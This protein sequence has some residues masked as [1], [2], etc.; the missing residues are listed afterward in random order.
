MKRYEAPNPSSAGRVTANMPADTGNPEVFDMYGKRIYL[1]GK[2]FNEACLKID[3]KQT[4]EVPGKHIVKFTG[5][6]KSF[7]DRVII[8]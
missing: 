4:G 6:E 3:L 7:T 5:G 2:A 1:K 8:A